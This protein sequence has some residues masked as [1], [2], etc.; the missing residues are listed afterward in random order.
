MSLST[1]IPF[2]LLKGR[3][4]FDSWEIGA[5]AYLT[6]KDLWV[7]TTKKPDATKPAEVT[8]DAKA[9]SE[10]ILLIDPTLYS[11]VAGAVST[12]DAWDS[13]TKAFHDSGTFQKIFTLV[14]F[15]TT[16]A[17]NFSTRQEYVNHML[18]LWRK[19]QTAGFSIDEK[20]AG[21]LMLGS[22]PAQYRPM[23]LGIE[24]SGTEITV[25]FV[26]NIILN[27]TFLNDDSLGEESALKA[28]VRGKKNKKNVQCYQC[29]GP[30]FRNK[31]P[32]L[33]GNNSK[34]EN[35]K[36]LY[37]AY[38][39][40]GKSDDWFIDSAATGDM[41]YDESGVEKLVKSR[42]G[43]VLAADG[44]KMDIIGVGTVKKLSTTN[45]V[46]ELNDVQ[47]IPSI[48]ANLL[49][50]A[51][52]V[53]KDYEVIFNKQ[54]C[55]IMDNNGEVVA[56]GRFENNLFKLN[57]QTDF[58][59]AATKSE[60]V[61]LWHRRLGH[62][63]L[64]NMNFLK[65]K[66][67]N[68]L[69]CKICIRGKQPRSA[70]MNTGTRAT[71]KLEIVHSDVCGPIQV[72]SMSGAKYFL[73][74]I[75]DF[76]RKVFVYVLKNKNQVFKCLTEFKNI[77]EKQSDC[78]LK[79]VRSDNGG[80][81]VNKLVA[82]FCEKYG[83]VHQRTAAYTPQQN[84]V[85][86]R[87]NRTLLDRVRCMLIDSNL[88]RVFWAEALTTAV[89]I[90]NFVPC[91]ATKD[92]SPEWLWSN[93]EPDLN[94]LRV[95]GCI[96]FAH[97]PNQKRKK[98]DDKGIECIFVGYS[99]TSKAYRLFNKT[100]KT[101]IVSRD[102]TFI[103]NDFDNL[104]GSEESDG[105]FIELTESC[106]S[107]GDS[108]ED[109]SQISDVEDLREQ[110]EIATDGQNVVA[111]APENVADET[112]TEERAAE[113]TVSDDS[114]G[115]AL[116]DTV[117]STLDDTLLDP[118]YATN[119]RVDSSA[120]RP[121]TRSNSLNPSSILNSAH[122]VSHVAFC[123]G[124]PTT[125]KQAL[126]SGEK[127]RWLAAMND[128]IE[129]MRVNDTWEMVQL[130]RDRKTIKNKW[131][132]AKKTDSFGNVVKY[133]ARLVAKGFTQRE[134]IDY[135]ETFSPVARYNSLRYLLCLVAE[136]DLNLT[137]MDAV[138]AFLNGPLSEE[139]YMEQPYHFN[140]NTNRVC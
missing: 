81:Y 135:T 111:E 40:K 137:Q 80:E 65:L 41:T 31:C 115:D 84:G 129:S 47:V 3:E 25:D 139:V 64:G 101:I 45:K 55:K 82:S 32:Q 114:F 42:K 22:L 77:A 19:V 69:K 105:F 123:T 125:V 93:R 90:V 50:V 118:T 88:P 109:D 28:V 120:N 43:H 107:G 124:T 21:S 1:K 75:D 35:E 54:G 68:G 48:C 51:K 92:K 86:E 127:D 5:R 134:G 91:K 112:R 61:K 23:I 44:K 10:L 13:I 110:E 89:R 131:V 108:D 113:T 130:P 33:R 87:M 16:K 136:L 67:P 53:K 126:E 119:A 7:W 12:K 14:K 62:V 11:Y 73:T 85:A 59:Y 76:T 103:E 52:L 117:A 79:T 106:K 104:C 38:V 26:K 94:T 140:D 95:F 116:N 46:L 36:A 72:N 56:T 8:A 83:I 132:F 133:K 57:T 20:T 18:S 15:V 2:D 39:A 122:I 63:N 58:A 37:C 29:K 98:L 4:N 100:N 121:V 9:K 78:Q 71:K 102:V 6:I 24:K 99:E 70:F 27:D 96:A 66:V 34:G 17:E 128:E 30:H 138:S 60:N 74:F 97:V 49:S